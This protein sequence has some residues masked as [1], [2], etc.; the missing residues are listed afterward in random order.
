MLAAFLIEN[1]GAKPVEPATEVA[2][3]EDDL[4]GD[5]LRATLADSAEELTSAWRALAELSDPSQARRWMCEPPPWPPASVAKLQTRNGDQAMTMIET[6]ASQVAPEP[7]LTSWLLRSWLTPARVVDGDM[8]AQL[9][10]AEGGLLA[11]EPRFRAWL[12][13]EW[14]AWARQRYRRVARQARSGLP[15]ADAQ[16]LPASPGKETD[17]R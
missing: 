7:R 13:A 10:R 14:T 3:V 2:P 17:T 12:R 8:I 4:L 11:R 1:L 5:L 6:L 9:A 16:A 15:I